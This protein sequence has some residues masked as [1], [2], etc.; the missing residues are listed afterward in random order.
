MSSLQDQRARSF[1]WRHGRLQLSPSQRHGYLCGCDRSTLPDLFFSLNGGFNK[2]VS[3]FFQRN[4]YLVH[5]TTV[6][7][8]VTDFTMR[9]FPAQTEVWAPVATFSCLNLLGPAGPCSSEPVRCYHLLMGLGL[10][11]HFKPRFSSMSPPVQVFAPHCIE[12]TA[13]LILVLN[14]T[15][16]PLPWNP[17]TLKNPWCRVGSTMGTPNG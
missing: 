17:V 7:E 8:I 11:G 16:P 9:R 3:R 4:H 5:L 13:S 2:F 10:E 12:F 14:A 6:Y 1:D 15:P